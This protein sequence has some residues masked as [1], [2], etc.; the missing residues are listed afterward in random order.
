MSIRMTFIHLLTSVYSLS[1]TVLNAE[2]GDPIK[3]GSD[4]DGELED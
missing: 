2:N 1:G 4:E 3:H